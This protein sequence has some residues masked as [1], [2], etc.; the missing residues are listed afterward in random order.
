MEVNWCTYC[1]DSPGKLS[2]C[3]QHPSTFQSL[4]LS[5]ILPFYV[6]TSLKCFMM[7]CTFSRSLWPSMCFR[8]QDIQKLAASICFCDVLSFWPHNSPFIAL[9][10][11]L[12]AR[13]WGP[14]QSW[15]GSAHPGY[16]VWL[17]TP[18]SRCERKL[19]KRNYRVQLPHSYCASL[20]MNYVMGSSNR[21]FE[22]KALT[23]N[24]AGII[25]KT[26]T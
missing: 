2:L 21:P 16:L 18:Q 23:Q 17:S 11:L 14:C 13:K 3:F 9:L 1:W 15:L 4:V 12:F 7:A 5:L 26:A 8:H 19:K 25:W 10:I 20:P 6:L 22:M 24:E